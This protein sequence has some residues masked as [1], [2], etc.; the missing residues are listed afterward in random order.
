MKLSALPFV[1]VAALFCAAGAGA[2][3]DASNTNTST[4]QGSPAPQT[5]AQKMAEKKTQRK[6]E[7]EKRVKDGCSAETA[8]GGVCAGKDFSSGLLKCLRMN[9]KKLAEGC[10]DAL[11]PRK[12]WKRPAKGAKKAAPES[13]EAPAA[14]QAPT[15]VP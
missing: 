14:P 13:Q 5:K 11:Y 10:K 12:K 15:P 7:W 9:R 8:D 2:Q 4:N 3:G 6:E 1:L